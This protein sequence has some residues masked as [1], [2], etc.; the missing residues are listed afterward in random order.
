MVLG[1]NHAMQRSAALPAIT[2]LALGG[3]A[4]AGQKLVLASSTGKDETLCRGNE[5]VLV[6]LSSD[7]LD[8]LTI[9]T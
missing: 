5:T 7:G 4:D 6:L 8:V 9:C 2:D 3:V 1:P